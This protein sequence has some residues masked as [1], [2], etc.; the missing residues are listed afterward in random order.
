[1]TKTLKDTMDK[2]QRTNVQRLLQAIETDQ[3]NNQGEIRELD[4]Q[5]KDLDGEYQKYRNANQRI[6]MELPRLQ[7]QTLT[8]LHKAEGDA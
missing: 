8:E 4:E 2:R 1:M 3:Q 6:Q 7:D 5:V